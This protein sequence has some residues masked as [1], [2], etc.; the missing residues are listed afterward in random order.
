MNTRVCPVCGTTFERHHKQKYCCEE[1]C[2]IATSRRKEERYHQLSR[3]ARWD[4]ALEQA[5]ELY[6]LAHGEEPVEILNK[7]ADY[8]YNNYKQRKG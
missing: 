6:K 5:Q 1:C 2:I 7:L 8:V 3:Q 4:W